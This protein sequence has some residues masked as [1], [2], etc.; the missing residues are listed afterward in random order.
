MAVR[1]HLAIGNVHLP[2]LKG[3][4]LAQRGPGC[5]FR[6]QRW[7]ESSPWTLSDSPTKAV[8]TLTPFLPQALYPLGCQCGGGCN[9]VCVRAHVCVSESRFFCY[10][11][12][13]SPAQGGGLPQGQ[14]RLQTSRLPSLGSLG[15]PH[16]PCPI[17]HFHS[18][19]C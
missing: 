2:F 12:A 4:C 13:A 7:P 17:S 5:S 19:P 10:F 15:G 9:R 6:T 11:L 3:E 8:T 18:G 1:N 14:K 16:R